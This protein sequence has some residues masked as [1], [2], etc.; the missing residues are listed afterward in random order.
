MILAS[1]QPN[2]LPYMGYLYKIYMADTFS[3]SDKVIYTRN[4]H[5][6]YNYFPENGKR[7]KI[8]IPVDSHSKPFE[9]V[10]LVEWQYNRKKV[11]KRLE[12]IYKR[13]PNF[14]KIF[15]SIKQIVDADYVT[16][17]DLNMELL[18]YIMDYF[19]LTARLVLESSLQLKYENPNDD[20]ISICKS[21]N[22]DKYVSGDG[23]RDYM[24][25]DKFGKN[26]IKVLW[27]KYEPIDYGADII[28]LSCLDYMMLK[29]N[30]LPIKWKI[31]KEYYNGI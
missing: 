30:E 28:N 27:T 4:V 17:M 31:D 13:Y 14:D 22:C 23:S 10:K 24:D 2:F 20:I 1:H 3:I 29:G 25:I 21:L 8:T 12:Q 9:E 16:L 18:S 7:T 26:G 19:S 15:P 11:L 6:N 5:H